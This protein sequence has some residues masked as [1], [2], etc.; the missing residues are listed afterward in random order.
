[1][2]IH[3]RSEES[4]VRNQEYLKVTTKKKNATLSFKI[5]YIMV[6]VIYLHIYSHEIFSSI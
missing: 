5:V 4:L 1:M 6:C 2:P 3:N